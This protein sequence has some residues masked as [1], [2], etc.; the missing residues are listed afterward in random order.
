MPFQILLIAVLAV[1]ALYAVTVQR[2]PMGM[3]EESAW[4]V[5]ASGGLPVRTRIFAEQ[6]MAEYP[7][8]VRCLAPVFAGVHAVDVRLRWGYWHE[9][10]VPEFEEPPDFEL[11]E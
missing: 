9:E 10:V 11:T 5:A 2:G 8:Q 7:R 4:E 1:S 3:R 6:R